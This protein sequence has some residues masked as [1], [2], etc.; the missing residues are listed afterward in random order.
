MLWDKPNDI[1]QYMD[2]I[3][4][5]NIVK[6]YIFLQYIKRFKYYINIDFNGNV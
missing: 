6:N 3:F 1:L 5:R 4:V 2:D